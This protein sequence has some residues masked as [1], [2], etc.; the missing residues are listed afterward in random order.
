M[1][2]TKIR[3]VGLALGIGVAL[4]GLLL[5]AQQ[6]E[7]ERFWGQWR[8]PCAC[9]VS[10]YADPPIEWSETKNVRW[11]VEIP[12][13]GSASPVVWGDRVFVVSAIRPSVSG[14]AAHAPRGPVRPGDVYRFVLLAI[15]RR[16]GH[17]L[18]ER[19]TPEERAPEGTNQDDGAWASSSA[20]TDGQQV[21]AFFGASGL[22]A[23]D[24]EGKLLWQK[25]LGDQSMR[26]EFAQGSTPGLYGNRLVVVWDHRGQSF[27]VALDKLTGQEIW[28][29]NREETDGWAT[30][31]LIEHEGRVQVLTIGI[32]R[33]RSYELETGKIVWESE[34][35]MLDPIPSP[36]AAD[37][38]AFVTGGLA[39]TSLAAIRLSEARG[40]I[41]GTQAVAWTL[42]RDTP[43]VSSP[44]LY[45][46][47]LYLLKGTSGILSAFDAKTGK[48]HYRLQRLGGVLN[49]YASPVGASGRVYLSGREGTTLV[50]RGGPNFEVLARNELDDRFDASPALVDKEIYL[51][52][53]RYLY[54]IAAQ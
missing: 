23:Y 33:L 9:G 14:T 17:V 29:A 18:W 42:D 6:P 45:D 20:V 35:V 38:M 13:W 16:D 2:K 40:D 24:M 10:R 46:G 28:R 34:G 27:I 5:T 54:S 31:L 1:R 30:P 3:A 43:H 7:A 41:A 11:K 8:G 48:P 49:A 47:I 36:V 52:G 44:L 51:R 53:Y 15:D 32:N 37:G 19:T 22:Y 21:F 25:D 12:G 39:D 26:A 50:I 4:L